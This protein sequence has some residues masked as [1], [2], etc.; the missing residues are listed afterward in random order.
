MVPYFP[1]SQL[2]EKSGMIDEICRGKW[3]LLNMDQEGNQ[4][5]AFAAEK[6]FEH[7]DLS[8]SK[9]ANMHLKKWM[10]ERQVQWLLLRPD[11]YIYAAGNTLA[12]L[13]KSYKKLQQTYHSHSSITN[14]KW[15]HQ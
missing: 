6:M 3:T 14:K 5:T 4:F 1:I 8:S 9:E 7:L 15:V 13:E 12:Q 10:Q 2:E 11:L